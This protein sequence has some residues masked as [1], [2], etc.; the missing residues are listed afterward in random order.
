MVVGC[1]F[2]GVP[3]PE[4]RPL[5]SGPVSSLTAHLATSLPRQIHQPSVDGLAILYLYFSERS[6]ACKS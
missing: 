2:S 3:A 1:V 5:R 6:S 4:S